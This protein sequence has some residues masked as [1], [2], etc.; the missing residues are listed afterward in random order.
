MRLSHR[1]SSK[2][3]PVAARKLLG[4]HP[5][6]RKA[7]PVWFGAQGDDEFARPDL[8]PWQVRPQTR[9][10]LWLAL[11]AVMACLAAVLAGLSG[12]LLG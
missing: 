2:S 4:D 3:A 7:K 5:M 1:R 6:S 10:W 12:A 8:F 11:A 9:R